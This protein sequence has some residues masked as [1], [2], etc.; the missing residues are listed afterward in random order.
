MALAR[1]TK[2][3]FIVAAKRTPFGSYGGKL[4]NYSAT[5]LQEIA[6]RGALAAGNI[7][8]S[9]INSVVV[10][11]VS[12]VTKDGAY[13]SRHAALRVGVPDDVPA[14]AVNRMCGS[15]FQAIV[16]AAQEITMGDA[17]IVLTGGAENMSLAPHT[18]HGARFG[19]KLGQ[20]LTMVDTLWQGLID[21]HV[22]MPMG[23]TA[24]NLAAKYEISREACDQFAAL[25]HANWKAGVDAGAF[26]EEIVPIEVKTRKG[27]V[28][29]DLDEHPKPGTTAEQLGKLP[30]VFMKN[31]TVNA[32]NAS[33]IC[34]GAACVILASE[35]ACKKHNLTPLARLVG[36]GIAGCDPKIMGIGP[37]PAVNK[38]LGATG[39][40][41]QDIDLVEINEAFAPQCLAVRKALDF[42]PEILNVNGGAIAI[43][44]PV[45]ASGSRISGHL[46]H[47][48]R[49]TGKKRAIGTACCGGGQGISLLLENVN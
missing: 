29:M 18:V 3:I 2:G 15:G 47:E 1:A 39:S 9:L 41:L 34:D 48:L 21:Q 35:E 12:Q 42:D 26:K 28:M 45:G 49:R 6:M 23:I 36:Y 14:L 7:D 4:M 33:G 37:V 43:G 10:G 32:G 24:E 25:S 19:A 17:E 27:K 22:K 40:K 13:L 30:A 38:M 44:H 8:P 16:T 5:D 11:N 46:V 20:D 31:G